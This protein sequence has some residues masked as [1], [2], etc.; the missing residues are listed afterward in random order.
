MATLRVRC[1]LCR[2]WRRFDGLMF[3]DDLLL[4]S[5]RSGGDDAFVIKIVEM[6]LTSFRL[7]SCDASVFEEALMFKDDLT[8][9]DTVDAQQCTI[10]VRSPVYSVTFCYYFFC[11]QV[12]DFKRS[13]F[14]IKLMTSKV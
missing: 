6:L 1:C 8:F 11:N 4:L 9:V 2:R 10:D 3:K 13:T 7:A 14:L 12:N 5:T